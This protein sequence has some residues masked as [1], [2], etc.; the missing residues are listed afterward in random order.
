MIRYVYR[1]AQIAFPLLV[2]LF[3][4][5]PQ[6]DLAISQSLWSP[7]T[8]FWGAQQGWM[9]LLH[10]HLGKVLALA[11]LIILCALC[12]TWIKANPLNI[13]RHRK[14]LVF[15]LV[16]AVVGPGLVVNLLLKDQWGRARPAQVAEF[17]GERQ[18]TSA[19]V[20]SDACGKNCS[21]VCGDASVGFLL[22]AGVFV[23]RR[24][25]LWL[26]AS[27]LAGGVLG[28]MRIAQGGHFFSDV[29]FSWYAV[30]FSVWL[31]A[32]W[33]RPGRWDKVFPAGNSAA[34]SSPHPQSAA[35]LVN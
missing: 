2:V 13:K 5:F 30:I 27:L 19:W 15:L 14:S 10:K 34:E 21:F 9:E 22:V 32:R 31:V 12:L 26:V 17:G 18:F 20:I 29:I 28:Y 23:S 25:R 3:L 24:P 4:L 16:A 35:S 7:Q 1:L 6:I 11:L 33:L 8:G